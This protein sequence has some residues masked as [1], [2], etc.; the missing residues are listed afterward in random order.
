MEM[1]IL[2]L[3]VLVLASAAALGAEPSGQQL[4]STPEEVVI[5]G[6]RLQLRDRMWAAEAKAYAIFNQFNDEKRFHISCSKSQPTGTRF[7]TQSCQPEFEIRATRA[8]A[9]QYLQSLQT[10]MEGTNGGKNLQG[11]SL[12][13]DGSSALQAAPMEVEIARQQE[14]YKRKFR[15]IAEK[16]PEFIRA[17]DEYR[18][19]KANYDKSGGNK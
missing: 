7:L 19:A 18:K 4:A 15:E 9:Q 1:R 14:D 12:M 16:H 11:G 3:M 17:I 8:H 5:T 2:G 13:T 10:F 6:Q